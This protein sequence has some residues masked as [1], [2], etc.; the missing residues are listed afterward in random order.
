MK[1]TLIQNV[2]SNFDLMDKDHFI[3]WFKSSKDW[4]LEKEKQQIIDSF[5]QGFR[6]GETETMVVD[7]QKDVAEYDDAIN[8]YNETYKK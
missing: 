1:N 6:E 8:Y 4:M 7:T 5:N 3:D 2:I